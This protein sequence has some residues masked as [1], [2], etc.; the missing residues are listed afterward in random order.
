VLLS[1]RHNASSLVDVVDEHAEG[2]FW[3]TRAFNDDP[4]N[5]GFVELIIRCLEVA[6]LT[7]EAF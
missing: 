2:D 7:V 3:A 6:S 5:T 1:G 4:Q